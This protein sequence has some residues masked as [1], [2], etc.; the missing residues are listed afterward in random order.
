VDLCRLYCE[1]GAS[2][3]NHGKEFAA[4]MM[5]LQGE[6]W[7][8]RLGDLAPMLVRFGETLDEIQ[9]YRDAFLLSLETT[10]CAPMEVRCGVHLTTAHDSYFVYVQEFVRREVKTVSKL[11][12]EMQ[13]LS[14]EHEK[15]LGAFL[16]VK[17]VCAA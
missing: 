16:K 10:F 2:F 1:A 15:M 9:S 11:K 13:A 14:I 8:T 4:E 7:F 17:Y 6:S 12:Q 5:H 3:G